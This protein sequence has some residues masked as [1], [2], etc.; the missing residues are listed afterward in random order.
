MAAADL[1]RRAGVSRQTIYAMEAG[2][3]VPNTAVALKL[4][5]A[6]DV[7]VEDLF[8]LKPDALKARNTSDVTLVGP[9][10]RFAGATLEL[11]RVGDRLVGVPSMPAPRQL[12]P[13][14]A[15][16]LNPGRGSVE[17]LRESD[18]NSLLIAGCDPAVSVLA[19]HLGRAGVRL[20]N[21]SVNSSVALELL[22]KGLVHVA[23]THLNR[24]GRRYP[25]GSSAYVFAD[26]EEG[27]VVARGNPHTIR[28][29]ADLARP[30]LRIVNREH[31]SGSRQLLDAQLRAA[32]VPISSVGGYDHP[33]ASGHLAAAWQVYAGLADA[34]VATRSAARAFGLDFLPLAGERYSLV[35]RPEHLALSPVQ[36]VLD[37][38]TRSA[39]CRE[40]EAI[41]GYD[42]RHSGQQV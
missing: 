3:F 11:C 29:V 39:F 17:V 8:H 32:G 31:G 42:T 2:D 24:R 36:R 13:A 38:L 23:G 26:W 30:S 18:E 12:P 41:T 22:G 15:L 4:A 9:A 40:L 14:D 37:T 16:L 28:G 21:A 19:R 5:R 6:L 10:D 27:L 7:S 25:V 1:A 20:V 35:I 34:C 33:P